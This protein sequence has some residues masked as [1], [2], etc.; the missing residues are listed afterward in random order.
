MAFSLSKSQIVQ[1]YPIS[2]PCFNKHHIFL[3]LSTHFT[4]AS[5]VQ[6]WSLDFGLQVHHYFSPSQPKWLNQAVEPSYAITTKD[7]R[8]GIYE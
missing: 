3:L 6:C 7:S 4:M 1:F 2:W 8:A 5:F